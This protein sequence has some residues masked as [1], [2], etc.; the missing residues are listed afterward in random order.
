MKTKEMKNMGSLIDL[1]LKID[2]LL[3]SYLEGTNYRSILNYLTNDK[4]K[5]DLIM[6]EVKEYYNK[7]INMD[8]QSIYYRHFDQFY[9]N[10]IVNIINK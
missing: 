8:W 2:E 7:F 4:N 9:I 5:I 3:V 6:I 1:E 10:N